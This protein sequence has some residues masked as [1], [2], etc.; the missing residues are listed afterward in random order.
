MAKL[1]GFKDQIS[2]FGLS[3]DGET[4]VGVACPNPH[5]IIIPSYVKEIAD[6]AFQALESLEAIYIHGNVKRIG[7]NA[8][9]GCTNLREIV[10]HDA[11]E[12][13]RF[14]NEKGDMDVTHHKP[15]SQ[16]YKSL[17]EGYE[18]RLFKAGEDT[19]WD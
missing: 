4:V 9:R 3:I 5:F 15:F 7:I 18:A 8:F 6:G 16:L 19:S 13:I 2:I 10:L 14:R 11:I 17:K 12:T 1:G